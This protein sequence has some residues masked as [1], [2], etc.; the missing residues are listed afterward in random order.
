MTTPSTRGVN[1]AD[2]VNIIRGG[3]YEPAEFENGAW[4]YRVLTNRMAAVLELHI[5]EDGTKILTVITCWRL[6]R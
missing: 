4:R 3:R 6:R 2:V 1:A 5:I